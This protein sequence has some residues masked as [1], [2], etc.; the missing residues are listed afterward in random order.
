ML[1]S[2]ARAVGGALNDACHR[3]PLD[4]RCPACRWSAAERPELLHKAFV[5]SETLISARDGL[6]GLANAIFAERLVVYYPERWLRAD[7]WRRVGI[8]AADE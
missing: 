3:L 1:L 7:L 6:V 8:T 2:V 5:D 4:P